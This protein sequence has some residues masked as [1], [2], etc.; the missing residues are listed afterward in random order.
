MIMVKWGII[1]GKNTPSW[2]KVLII[3]L[4][5]LVYGLFISII[6][7]SDFDPMFKKNRNGSIS[8]DDGKLIIQ[9]D[10]DGYYEEEDKTFYILGTLTNN[11]SNYYDYIELEY[12]VYDEEGNILGNASTTLNQLKKGKS[13]RFKIAYDEIDAKEVSSFELSNINID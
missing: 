7:F 6:F 8:I 3:G 1:M 4:T 11:T 5:I 2:L 13:W 12:I 9:K 10:I